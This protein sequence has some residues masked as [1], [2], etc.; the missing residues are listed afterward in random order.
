MISLAIDVG[1]TGAVAS[2]DH[3][4]RHLN[5]ADLPV[6]GGDDNRVQGRALLDLLREWVPAGDACVLIVED[7]RPRPQ[8]NGGRAQN[9]MHSQGSLMRS[10]GAIEA[11]A[12]IMGVV[13]VWV[14]PQTWKRHFGLKAVRDAAR[15]DGQN[16]AATKEL[17]RQL[18][19]R[20]M[21]SMGLALARKSDHNRSEALLLAYWGISTQL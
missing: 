21:P 3:T 14:Q 15:S 20:M 5:V 4:R 12:D 6:I 1:L 7:V 9:T 16:S 19:L 18:A 13:P 8:G 10:R 11:V 2:I 17:S